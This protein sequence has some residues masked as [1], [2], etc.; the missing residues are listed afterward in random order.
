MAKTPVC[1]AAATSSRPLPAWKASYCGVC[2]E[3]LASRSFSWLPVRSG[4]AAAMSAAAPVTCGVAME[5]PLMVWYAP[6]SLPSKAE[7]A[8]RMSTPGAVI[9]G[10]RAPSTRGPWLEKPATV[11]EESTAPTVSASVAAPGAPMVPG[12]PE[13]PAATTNSAPV[14]A[15][16]RSTAWLSGSVPSDDPSSPR[17]MLTTLACWSTAAHSMPASTQESARSRRCPAPCRCRGGRRVRLPAPCRR[18]PHR[19]RR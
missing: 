16:S 14:W 5:V 9:S 4:W 2:R 13:L 1:A 3:L 19:C 11:S 8:A 7:L 18:R 10:F 12:A 17:L 6:R 15:L